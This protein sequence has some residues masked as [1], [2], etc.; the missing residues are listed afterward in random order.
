MIV[1]DHIG[2]V[3]AAMVENLVGCFDAEHAE[4]LAFLRGMEFAR[5]FGVTCFSLQVD[6]QTVVNKINSK[7]TDLSVAGH[8]IVGI[9][10]MIQNFPDVQVQYVKRKFNRLLMQQLD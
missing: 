2:E 6:A 5:D 10:E 7:T 9:R 1:R 4:T 3:E 8:L